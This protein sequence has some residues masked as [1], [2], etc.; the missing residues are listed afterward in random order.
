MTVYTFDS[1]DL[2]QYSVAITLKRGKDQ[3]GSLKD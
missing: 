3:S 1:P 2:E